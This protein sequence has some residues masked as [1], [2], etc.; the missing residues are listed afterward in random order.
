MNV[1][2]DQVCPPSEPV[3]GSYLLFGG[4]ETISPIPS[5][6]NNFTDATVVVAH[7]LSGVQVDIVGLN[8]G[9]VDASDCKIF[10]MNV[11]AVQIC[12]SA[13]PTNPNALIA[14]HFLQETC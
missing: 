7:E 8:S 11:S 13:S 2:R 6:I 3:C 9:E 12:L 5:F 4:Y 14:S 1:R 10:G